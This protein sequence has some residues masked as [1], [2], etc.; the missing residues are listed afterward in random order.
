MKELAVKWLDRVAAF[1][2]VD[3]ATLVWAQ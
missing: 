2:G 1:L 3:D